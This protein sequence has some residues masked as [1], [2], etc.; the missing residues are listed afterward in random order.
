MR[1][2]IRIGLLAVSLVCAFALVVASAFADTDDQLRSAK[3][4]AGAPLRDVTTAPINQPDAGEFVNVG[5]VELKTSSGVIICTEMEFG[6]TVVNN[7]PGEVTLALPF[8]VAEGDNCTNSIVG[9]V[10]TYFDTTAEGAVGVPGPPSKVATITITDKSPEVSPIIATVHNLLFSQHIP[11]IGWCTGNVN[12]K[13][14]KVTN[15]TEPFGEEGAN[16]LKVRFETAIPI[17]ASPGQ[18]CSL[19]GTNAELI[20]EFVL[21]TP[22]TTTDGAWFET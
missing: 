10:P 15:G 3:A 22:S 13:E 18:T 1:S 2:S 12:G 14:G 11:G 9:I 5:N 6:T 20:A 8:G 4:P 17:T 16:G 7:K 21:E 19:A